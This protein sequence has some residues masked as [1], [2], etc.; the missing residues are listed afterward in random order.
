ME[1]TKE[2]NKFY[3]QKSRHTHELTEETIRTQTRPIRFKPDIIPALRRDHEWTQDLIHC[4]AAVCSWHRPGK[5][6]VI[7]F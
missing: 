6:K 7:S 4:P 2:T 3:A 1:E 5:G